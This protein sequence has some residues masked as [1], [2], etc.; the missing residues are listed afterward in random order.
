MTTLPPERTSAAPLESHQAR[1]IAESFG[2]DADR[3]D[4]TRPRYPQGLVD[5]IVATSP[6]RSVLDVG[7]GTGIVARQLRDAGCAVLGVEADARMAEYARR[8]G[9]DVEVATFEAWDAAGRM[10][11]AVV[12]GQAWH[13]VDPVA[14]AAKAGQVL[15]PGGRFAAFWN[16][17]DPPDAVADATTAVHR[18]MMPAAAGYPSP[19]SSGRDG[20][21][22]P[23]GRGGQERRSVEDAYSAIRAKAKEGLRTAGGFDEP[24]EW[25]FDWEHSYTKD[26]WL[27][28]VPTSGLLTRLPPAQLD[29]VLAEIGAAVDAVG[30]GFTVR[31]STIVITATWQRKA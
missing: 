31:Y 23:G 10:F 11:D 15:R 14:G 25:R 3:Y 5:R 4:R 21:D 2:V 20:R 8:S 18:R 28:Q 30:G 27:D 19:P 7:I 17:G 9:I 22:T 13:W 12:A 16:A 1:Q 26:E 6:G 29:E 24:E